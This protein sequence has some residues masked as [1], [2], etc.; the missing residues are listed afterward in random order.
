MRPVPKSAAA[1]TRHRT[2]PTEG[3][4][5]LHL[6]LPERTGTAMMRLLGAPWYAEPLSADP[7][8]GKRSQLRRMK[9]EDDVAPGI[10]AATNS[11]PSRASVPLCSIHTLPSRMSMWM[12]EPWTRDR[13]SSPP[14]PPRSDRGPDPRRPPSGC[15]HMPACNWHTPRSDGE[16][17]RDNGLTNPSHHLLLLGVEN[18][19]SQTNVRDD[20]PTQRLRQQRVMHAAG[21]AEKQ[22]RSGSAWDRTAR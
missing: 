1:T 16:R 2:A 18:Q 7:V 6:G 10:P 11:S 20:Q 22:R 14:G 9:A 8:A 19:N 13:R 12:I 21:Y 3:R 4:A 17:S 5:V 15:R